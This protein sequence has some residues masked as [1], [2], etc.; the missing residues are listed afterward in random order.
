[1]I[2]TIVSLVFSMQPAF[3]QERP[4]IF[5][6]QLDFNASR[7]PKKCNDVATFRSI[8][9]AW[10]DAAQ[11]RDDAERRLLVRIVG[12]STGGKQATVS[13][14]DAQG[15]TTGKWHEDFLAQDEC[16]YT[17][18]R[19][20][21]EA[22]KILGAFKPPPPKEAVACPACAACPSC[23]PARPCPTCPPLRLSPPTITLSSPPYRSFIAIGTFVASG[24]YSE[25]DVGPY[26]ILGFVPSRRLPDLHVEFEGSW[27]SQ[28]SPFSITSESIRLHSIPLAGSFCW[29]RGIVRFCGGLA[30][31]ILLSNQSSDND[32]LHVMFGPNFRVGTELFTRGPFAIRADVF[33]RL[34]FAQRKFGATTMTLDDPT[35]FAAGLAVTGAWAFP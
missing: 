26:A 11:L 25:L 2:T 22:A 7:A 32:P 28:S 20:A 19:T 6:T 24:I 27:T 16:H 21:R 18:W 13:L 35:R 4:V 8:L 15:F 3:G 34:A 17:L 12:S 30:T 23:P 31:T 33:G 5:P 14:I 29:V 1:L 9:G 10:M